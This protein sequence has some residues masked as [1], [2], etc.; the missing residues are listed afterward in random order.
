MP[1]LAVP[2]DYDRQLAGLMDH[3]MLKPN[4]TRAELARH[5][6]EAMVYGFYSVCI[7]PS[8]IPFCRDM[9]AGSAVKIC[10]VAG[11]PQ[12]AATSRV[13]AF[14]TADAVALGA[15]EVDMVINI[16]ALKSGLYDYVLKDIQA[17][18]NEA[19]GHALTKVILETGFLTDEEKVRACQLAVEAGADYVKTCTG[20]A[21]GSAATAADIAL[22]RRTV[23][24]HIGVKAAGGVRT[25]ED[26]MAVVNAG[27]TR[28]GSTATIA[29][30]TRTA[31]A[32]AKEGSY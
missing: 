22:M 15:H 13:K 6:E 17:V 30:V 18:V 1:T 11:F 28:I 3:S 16:H 31:Q 26:A 20:F 7:Q 14:E 23:G 12:G 29:I 5:C 10:T 21:P 27:A 19:K 4:A 24:P 8:Y 25:Y 32:Q 9:L 2:T